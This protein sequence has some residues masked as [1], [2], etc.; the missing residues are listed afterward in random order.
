MSELKYVPIKNIENQRKNNCLHMQKI[1]KFRPITAYE[2]IKQKLRI[3][4]ISSIHQILK[5]NLKEYKV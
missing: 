2:I 3:I 4:N 1:M 5:N